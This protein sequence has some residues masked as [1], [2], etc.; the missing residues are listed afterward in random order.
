MMGNELDKSEIDASDE[1]ELGFED[2][3][4]LQN[5]P[6]FLAWVEHNQASVKDEIV[7]DGA[8]F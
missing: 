8:P 7:T 2:D 4:N 6:E 5:D 1:Q 3:P